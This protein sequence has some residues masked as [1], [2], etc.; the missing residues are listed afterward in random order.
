MQGFSS[1]QYDCYCWPDCSKAIK[2]VAIKFLISDPPPSS[3]AQLNFCTR[4]LIYFDKGEI[5]F[6]QL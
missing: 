3:F 2:A 5:Y 6:L 1:T 4:M